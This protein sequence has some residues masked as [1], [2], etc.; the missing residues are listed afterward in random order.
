M[1]K[2]ITGVK[3]PE[4]LADMRECGRML[5]T[6]YQELRERVTAGMSELDV[7]DY[8]AQR[9]KEFGAEATYLTE[10]VAQ[11]EQQKAQRGIQMDAAKMQIEGAAKE[12]EMAL[13]QRAAEQ[14]MQ[15]K[16]MEH[17][18]KAKQ[19]DAA[20]QASMQQQAQQSQLS[21]ITTAQAAKQK[22]LQAQEAA[23]VKQQTIPKG[24]KVDGNK[25]K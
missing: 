12:Q 2:L 24:K 8:V 23:K 3:T 16:L 9:I 7:N 14:D 18:L 1:S 5:A 22:N 11:L 13:K 17:V 10:E 19:A 25:S 15:L 4:Q 21:L 20:H 6:I